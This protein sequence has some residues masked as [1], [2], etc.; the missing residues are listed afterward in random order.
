MIPALVIDS[1]RCMGLMYG[2]GM[3]M[4]VVVFWRLAC[5]VWIDCTRRYAD[6]C[7]RVVVVCGGV[8]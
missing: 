8:S 5:D 1:L 2:G 6:A 4:R 7:V 3:L